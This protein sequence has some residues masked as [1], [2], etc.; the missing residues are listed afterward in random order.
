[1]REKINYP[2][3]DLVVQVSKYKIIVVL[4]VVLVKK[5]RGGSALGEPAVSSVGAVL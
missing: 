2:A 1:M 3:N 5:E 4:A